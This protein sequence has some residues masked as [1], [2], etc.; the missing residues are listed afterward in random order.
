ME[1]SISIKN[2]QVAT[3]GGGTYVLPGNGTIKCTYASGTTT[4]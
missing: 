4:S 2:V 1:S 3:V